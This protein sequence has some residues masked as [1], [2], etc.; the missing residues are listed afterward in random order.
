MYVILLQTKSSIIPTT[1]IFLE[2]R[3][4]NRSY[5]DL[6]TNIID[7]FTVRCTQKAEQ[8][9]LLHPFLYLNYAAERQEV[10]PSYGKDSL[11]RLRRVRDQYDP[12]RFFTTFQTGPFKLG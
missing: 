4:C 8:M 3:W 12:D 5:D 11:N 2:I 10:F 1:V 7:N 9:G 6:F